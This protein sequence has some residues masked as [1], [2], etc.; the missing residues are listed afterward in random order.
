MKTGASQNQ[1]S[2]QVGGFPC[3]RCKNLIRFPFQAL[4][5]QPSIICTH[6]GLELQIDPERSAAALQEL[7][8][9]T[10][11]LADA[12]SKLDENKLS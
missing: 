3:P 9:Y 4:L 12:Q 8:K 6:C 5:Q 2:S 1:P 7:H 10:A 11:G